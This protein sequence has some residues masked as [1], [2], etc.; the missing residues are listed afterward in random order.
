MSLIKN[1]LLIACFSLLLGCAAQ[2]PVTKENYSGFMSDEQYSQLQQVKLDN[3][4]T[5]MR[6]ISPEL[7]N[8]QYS[9]VLIEPVAFHPQPKA[10]EQVSQKTLSALQSL[11][12]D[13]ITKQLKQSLPVADQPAPDVLKL[14]IVIT[15]VNIS[16]EPLA[17]Y[18][19]IPVALIASGVNQAAGGR[20][21]AVN[22]FAEAKVSDSVNGT[23]MASGVRSITGE[24]LENSTEKLQAN[25][26]DEGFA[27]A[28]DD[29]TDALAKLL[30]Q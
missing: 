11:L 18:Q 1:G 13:H 22:L 12:T 27:L 28:S 20:D 8:A 17:A 3:G 24:S 19:Y 25:D 29:L 6:W 4:N 9:K 21:Q 10:T 5:V 14:E 2:S 30:N 7:G 23:L 15:G 16:N 26:L